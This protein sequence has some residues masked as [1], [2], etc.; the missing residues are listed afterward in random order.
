MDISD[1]ICH[2]DDITDG[3]VALYTEYNEPQLFHYNEPDSGLFIAETPM[4]IERAM[5]CGARALSF[6]VES[7]ALA[8]ADVVRVLKR[9]GDDVPVFTAPLQVINRITGFNLTRGMLAAF[10][11]PALPAVSD[12]LKEKEKVAVLEDIVN[13]T[14]VGAIFRSAAAL[15]IEGILLTDSCTDPFY[16]RSARVSMGTV[17]M[18]PWTYIPKD[19]DIIEKLHDK[20]FDVISMALTKNAVPLTDPVLKKNPKRAVIF[21]AEGDGI[22]EMTLSKSDHIAIIPMHNGVDSLNVA[23]ASAVT[24]WELC[25]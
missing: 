22:S 18:I 21:G 1:R 12:L 4:V 5:D 25:R 10:E 23:S 9:T 14:N 11:R 19:T 17:F 6:F 3:R 7:A 2:I 16:R 13:P 20:H 8:N 24:F 15:G